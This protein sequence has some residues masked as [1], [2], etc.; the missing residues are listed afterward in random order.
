MNDLERIEAAAMRDAVR[1]GG[2]RAEHVG[3]AVCLA[4]PQVP[5]T[6]MNRALPLGESID[7]DAITRWY[8]ELGTPYVVQVTPE[9]GDLAAEL[10]H[11]GFTP[12]YAWMKFERGREPAAAH[13][14]SLTIAETGDQAA[15]GLTVAEGFGIPAATAAIPSAVVGLPGWTCF[16]AWDGDEPA[17]AAAVFVDGA[18]AWLG[19]AATRPA[20]RGRG[21]QNAL[22]AARI[23]AG[24]AD[25]VTTFVTETGERLPDRPAGSYRNVLRGG[26]REA[27]LRANWIAPA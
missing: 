4:H 21:A 19:I 10:E 13:D 26:F 3:G 16:V 24:R 14:T 5:I 25:G 27:Y 23:E 11:R 9:R 8:A 12:G 15:F 2:G 20:F 17:A 1:A 22:I 7:L 6:E 18:A